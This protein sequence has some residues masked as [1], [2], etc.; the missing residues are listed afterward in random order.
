VA[1]DDAQ[2][3]PLLS[4]GSKRRCTG[5]WVIDRTLLLSSSKAHLMSSHDARRTLFAPTVYGVCSTGHVFVLSICY[6]KK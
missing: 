5:A 2:H 6:Y 3:A 4:C 1:Q